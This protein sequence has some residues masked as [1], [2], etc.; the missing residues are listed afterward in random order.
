MKKLTK[1]KQNKFKFDKINYT[2]INSLSKIG[3]INYSKLGKKLNISH[4]SIKNRYENLINKKMIK[5]RFL[6][7]CSLLGFS[8]GCLLLEIDS[9]GYEQLSK[10]YSKCP[11]II[12]FFNI[13]GEYNCLL[14][15]YAENLETLETMLKSCMLYNLKGVRKSNIMIFGKNNKDIYLPLNF[16]LLN[17]N[18]DNTPCETC[19]KDCRAFMEEK[20]IGC[21]ASNFYKGPLKIDK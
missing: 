17:N 18:N 9:N 5:P 7:N 19:C 3:K 2:I 16:E 8:L 6:L 10:I 4:V 13:I 20:C 14:L 12:Y 21:P 1:T 15:F 11:R